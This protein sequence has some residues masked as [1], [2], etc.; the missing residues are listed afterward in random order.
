MQDRIEHRPLVCGEILTHGYPACIHAT[1]YAL[2][3]IVSLAGF[4]AV[5]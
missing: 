3:A 5:L 1:V 2:L 4:L